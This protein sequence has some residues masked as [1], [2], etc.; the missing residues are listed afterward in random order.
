M[1]KAIKYTL[2]GVHHRVIFQLFIVFCLTANVLTASESLISLDHNWEVNPSDFEFSM[3]L[4]AEMD[5]TFFDTNQEFHELGVFVGT[6][7]RGVAQLTPIESLDRDLFFLTI[8]SNQVGEQLSFEVYDS[9]QHAYIRLAENILFTPD[10]HLGS[11]SDPMLFTP[12]NPTS[13]ADLQVLQLKVFPNPF[14]QVLNIESASEGK[15]RQM[16]IFHVNGQ[17]LLHK[18]SIRNKELERINTSNWIPGLYIIQIREED[19]IVN[20]PILKQP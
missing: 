18:M 5:A 2:V 14:N 17:V 10:I 11:I 7:L 15:D 12:L 16:R 20:H 3:T 9:L 1:M 4:I 6:E 19:K 13:V 8:Y